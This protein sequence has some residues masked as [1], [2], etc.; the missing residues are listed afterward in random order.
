MNPKFVNIRLQICGRMQVRDY[1]LI[2]NIEVET[3][4]EESECVI[5]TMCNRHKAIYSYVQTIH[6]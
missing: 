5:V 3:D 1:L 2:W 4:T 6:A